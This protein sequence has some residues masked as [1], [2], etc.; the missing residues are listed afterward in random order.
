[1]ATNK[2]PELTPEDQ[3]R[4]WSHVDK[5]DPNGCWLWLG[6]KNKKGYGKCKLRRREY[7]TNRVSYFMATGEDPG[8]LCVCHTCDTPSCVRPEHLWLGDNLENREDMR[9]KGRAASGDRSGPRLHPERMPR[10]EGHHAATFTAEQV[11]EIR[12]MY[13]AGGISQTELARQLNRSKSTIRKIVK[14]T[15]WKHIT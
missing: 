13:D 8:E 7:R 15:R 4:F 1:M 11:L 14:R 3:G 12:R 9:L 6:K 10:G 5:S 2:I